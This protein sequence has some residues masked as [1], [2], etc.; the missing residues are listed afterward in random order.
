M[1]LEFLKPSQR[2]RVMDLVAAAGIDVSDWKSIKGGEE[3][4]ASNPKYC[5][6]WSYQDDEKKLIVLNLW[7]RNLDSRDGAVIQELNLRETA[8]NAASSPQSRRAKNM[9]ACIQKAAELNWPLRVIICDGIQRDEESSRTKSSADRRLLDNKPWHVKSYNSRTG[10]C[11]LARGEPVPKY[12]DQFEQDRHPAKK[13][14]ITQVFER[15]SQVRKQVLERAKGHCE[16]CG[17]KGFATSSGSTYLETHHI[18]PLS[19][20]GKDSVENVVA[21]CPNHHREA[22]FGKNSEELKAELL[23]CVKKLNK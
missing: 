18:Q 17:A 19:E 23:E 8:E 16:W 13:E 9:D 4:A 20:N 15:S 1:D 5:Y 7:Y 21:L 12:V 11:I 14:T 22:H 3:K 2:L 10:Q 6:E